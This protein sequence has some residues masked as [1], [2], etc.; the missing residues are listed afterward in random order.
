MPLTIKEN[1]Y[2]S[3]VRSI[4]SYGSKSWTM[5]VENEKKK[6]KWRQHNENVANDKLCGIPWRIK[7]TMRGFVNWQGWIK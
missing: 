3:Y 2:K 4:L 5:S 6:T 7:Y 1:L